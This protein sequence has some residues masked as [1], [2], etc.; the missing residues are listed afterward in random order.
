MIGY[1]Y[2]VQFG[3]NCTALDQSKLSN[4]VACTISLIINSCLNLILAI[5]SDKDHFHSFWKSIKISAL[6]FKH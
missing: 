4:F 5:R 1:S 3:I 6:Y 2:G